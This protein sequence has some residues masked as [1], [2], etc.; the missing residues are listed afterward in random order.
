MVRECFTCTGE[1]RREDR[2]QGKWRE[3]EREE[4]GGWGKNGEDRG[5]EEER[6]VRG[7]VT[8][9]QVGMREL[10]R[11]EGE[12]R[13]ERMRWRRKEVWKLGLSVQCRF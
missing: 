11:K 13:R 3:R 8:E 4:A 12:M 2:D 9:G 5:K 6:E 1:E 7:G 10:R